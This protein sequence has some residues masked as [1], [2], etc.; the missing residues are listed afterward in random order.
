MVSD[1]A[2]YRAYEQN[3][4]KLPKRDR[5]A[6]AAAGPQTRWV[7]EAVEQWF[8]FAYVNYQAARGPSGLPSESTLHRAGLKLPRAPLRVVE[9]IKDPPEIVLAV[10]QA[11]DQLQASRVRVLIACEKFA[12]QGIE[13]ASRELG[14]SVASTK[15]YL[16]EARDALAHVLR[17]M[18]W[19]VPKED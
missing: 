5:R 7:M 13:R 18:G 15:K 6:H 2:K 12:G 8:N 4:A 1:E 14:M 19:K 17:G 9:L 16:K 11:I 3:V 10:N